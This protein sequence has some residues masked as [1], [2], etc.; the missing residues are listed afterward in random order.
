MTIDNEGAARYQGDSLLSREE[1]DI[2]FTLMVRLDQKKVNRDNY[3]K[4]LWPIYLVLHQHGDKVSLELKECIDADSSLSA[5]TY[6]DLKDQLEHDSLMNSYGRR[7][8]SPA[9]QGVHDLASMVKRAYDEGRQAQPPSVLM[10]RCLE[11]LPDV[12]EK[13]SRS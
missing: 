2:I 7:S 12:R 6:E 5:S 13:Y 4:E 3:H 10:L 1:Q 8:F 11:I 9:L